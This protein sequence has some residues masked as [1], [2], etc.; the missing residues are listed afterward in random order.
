MPSSRSRASYS[1]A[2]ASAIDPTPMNRW[3]CV[4]L[5]AETPSTAPGTTRAP[6]II[7]SPCTG[8]T[9]C[10][11]TVAPAHHLLDRKLAQSLLDDFREDGV[12]LHP[13]PG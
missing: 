4:V 7:T 2:L 3:P 6:C 5:L 8:R 13:R 9:N 11:V 1:S 12:E 10:A